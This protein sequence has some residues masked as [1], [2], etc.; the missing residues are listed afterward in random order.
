MRWAGHVECVGG[1]INAWNLV[2]WKPGGKRGFV[3]LGIDCRILLKWN[4]RK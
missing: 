3:L 2:V 4:V 1:K